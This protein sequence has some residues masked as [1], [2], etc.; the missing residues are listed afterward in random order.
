MHLNHPYI[1][2]PIEKLSF[3]NGNLV[4]KGL[5]TAAI[6]LCILGPGTV[7]YEKQMLSKSWSEREKA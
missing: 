6:H 1:T 7:S 2:P 4:P 5:G 3:R